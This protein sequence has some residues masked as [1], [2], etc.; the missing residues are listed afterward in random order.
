VKPHQP[1]DASVES[2]RNLW[3][4]LC[5]A[6]ESTT[7][8]A[9]RTLLRACATQTALSKFR[10]DEKKIRPLALNTL[11]A[12]AEKAVEPG[13]WDKLEELRKTLYLRSLS[14]KERNRKAKRGLGYRLD[15]AA[16]ANKSL[17]ERIKNLL[18]NRVALLQAYA[19]AIDLLKTFRGLDANLAQRLQRHESMFD[20]K[21]IATAENSDEHS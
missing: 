10:C 12:A 4:E 21:L 5:A 9:S 3:A 6:T 1:S 2:V 7:Y 17:Q 11:K 8:Y 20:L 18:L 14:S 19:D 16:E 15:S 13:G